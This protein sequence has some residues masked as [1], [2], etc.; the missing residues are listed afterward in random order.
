MFN[1]KLCSMQLN[2][3]R[4]APIFKDAVQISLNAMFISS[5]SHKLSVSKLLKSSKN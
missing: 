5:H 2:L 4:I 1:L 3:K